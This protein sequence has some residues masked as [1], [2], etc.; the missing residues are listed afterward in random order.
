MIG[1]CLYLL[2][3]FSNEYSKILN[4]FTLIARPNLPEQLIVRY[5]KARVHRENVEQAVFFSG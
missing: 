4:I 2:P 3:Q 1:V 5:H